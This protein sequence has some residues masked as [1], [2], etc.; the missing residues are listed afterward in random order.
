MQA[1][2]QA[3]ADLALM[4]GG[5]AAATTAT[6][7][8]TATG[9]A[10]AAQSSKV[11]DLFAA[12]KSMPTSA[13]AVPVVT[14]DGTPSVPAVEGHDALGLTASALDS[15]IRHVITFIGALC[16]VISNYYAQPTAPALN[17]CHVHPRPTLSSQRKRKRRYQYQRQ[18]RSARATRA[19]HT[20]CTHRR[21]R[22]TPRGRLGPLRAGAAGAGAVRYHGP[23]RAGEQRFTTPR[24]TP[25]PNPQTQPST[26]NPR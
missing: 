12:F 16:I 15:F 1:E 8:A 4:R 3:A 10:A 13:S 9:T 19:T 18:R 26:P 11:D 24:P 21:A 22:Q 5:S 14:S 23:R 7:T 6:A 2:E 20:T 17:C 25:T